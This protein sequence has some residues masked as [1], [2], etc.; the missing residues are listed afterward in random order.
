M[1]EASDVYDPANSKLLALLPPRSFPD[2]E[3]V[4]GSR[5]ALLRALGMRD[6]LDL[7]GLLAAAEDIQA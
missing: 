2:A 5:G 3:F 4:A 6:S 7:Q 1:V